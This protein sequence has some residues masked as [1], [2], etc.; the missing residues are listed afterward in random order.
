MIPSGEAYKPLRA[1]SLKSLSLVREH[2]E[3][4]MFKYKRFQL[5][6][7]Y[8]YNC[9]IRFDSFI[10][11]SVPPT[12]IGNRSSVVVYFSSSSRHFHGLFI[13]DPWMIEDFYQ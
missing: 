5:P 7:N 12:L 13:R 1:V 4:L 3:R 6:I 9:T 2:H 10:R 8:C 11:L